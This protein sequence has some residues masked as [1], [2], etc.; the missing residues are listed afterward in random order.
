MRLVPVLLA[1]LVFALAGPEV[2]SLFRDR[3]PASGIQFRLNNSPTSELYLVETMTGGCAFIDYDGDGLLDIFLVNGAALARSPDGSVRVDK[4]DP[5]FWNRLY[6]NLGDG[7]F[8]DVTEPAGLKGHGFGM[9]VAVG[10]FDN[11]GRPDLLVTNYGTV[12]VYHNEG[13]GRF[14]EAAAG[15][16]SRGFHSSA[17]FFD[18]DND[19]LLDLFLCRYLQ[20]TFEA[21][22]DCRIGS[23]RDYCHPQNFPA[24]S[25]VLYKNTGRGAFVD[26]S[27]RTGVARFAGKALGVAVADF[28]RDGWPDLYIANDS[29]PAFLLLN[30]QGRFDDVGL[31]SAASVNAN[32]ATF[33]GMGVDAA[34]VNN[35]G[36]PDVF[37]TALPLEGFPLFRN[38]RDNTFDDVAESAGVRRATLPLSGW[39]VKLF[40]YDNDGWKDV[41]VANG[42]VMSNI[43]Q[44][45]RTLSYAQPLLLLRN[46]HGR[47]ETPGPGMRSRWASRGAAFGDIDNDG[48]IDV[49]V[50]VL[51]GSPLLLENTTGSRRNWIGLQ[52]E[53]RKSNREGVGA[54]VTT[55][56]PDGQRQTHVAGR[57][58][59]YLAS[60]D[61]RVVVGLGKS[62]YAEVEVAWPSGSLQKLGR[63]KSRAYHRVVE[64]SA[65]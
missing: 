44:S 34:D 48:D 10:D 11:D 54:V 14:Q 7:K 43:E 65:H 49:L 13:N 30:R 28:N 51:G 47:F 46:D 33:A 53:G 12:E 62:E 38:N 37:V 9:G 16:E 64:Q 15:V 36:W 60:N 35:D 45:M 24:V 42:H 50:Q 5:R 4:S 21:N 18:Y 26:V 31:E 8:Q 23:V 39:G 19:G 22:K 40:D 32:G 6:R 63:L 41:F 29:V 61:P 58:G 25:N 20:W 2:E 27:E 55:T 57:S 59:S 17:A 3:L 1:T 56:T 52:L